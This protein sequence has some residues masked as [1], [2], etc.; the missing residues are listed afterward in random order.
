MFVFLLTLTI[1]AFLL[2]ITIGAVRPSHSSLSL[3][4]LKRRTELGNNRAKAVLAREEKLHDIEA[5]RDFVSSLLLVF[6][7]ILLVA[8]FGWGWGLVLS[9]L[10]VIIFSVVCKTTF[11]RRLARKLYKRSRLEKVILDFIEKYHWVLVLFGSNKN[12][13]LSEKKI[14][15]REEL[16]YVVD[17][18][19]SDVISNEDKQVIVNGLSFDERQIYE[20]MTPRSDIVCVKKTELLGPLVL[21]DLHK[22]EHQIIPVIDDNIDHVVGVLRLEKLLTLDAKRSVTAAKALENTEVTYVQDDQTLKQALQ[23]LL[24]SN[25]SLAIVTDSNNRTVGVVT[26]NDIMNALFSGNR[27]ELAPSL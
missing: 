19:D 26:L 6:I 8:N 7:V 21:D 3:F 13:K 14:G 15:S 9:I 5:M 10:V 4:E 1:L 25:N 23:A 22:T 27:Q 20:I 16:V 2:M 12:D 11:A 18:L 17:Q 24:D